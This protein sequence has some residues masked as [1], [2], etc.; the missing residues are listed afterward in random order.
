MRHTSTRHKAWAS[1]VF[2]IIA[3]LVMA[4]GSQAADKVTLSYAVPSQL[5]PG[6]EAAVNGFNK[7]YAKSNVSVDLKPVNANTFG[8][9]LLTQLQAGN[10]PDLFNVQSGAGSA[11]G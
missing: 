7:A 3:L 11:F 1:V 10:A 5:Q 2:V 9:V 4:S 6:F 8:P